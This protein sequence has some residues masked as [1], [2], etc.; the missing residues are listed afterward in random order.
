[1]AQKD[2]NYKAY[3]GKKIAK[4]ETERVD[5]HESIRKKQLDLC[6]EKRVREILKE[7]KEERREKK[8][9]DHLKEQNKDRK[10]EF[11]KVNTK[12]LDYL[13]RK[14]TIRTDLD[15]EGYKA[16]KDHIVEIDEL[17]KHRIE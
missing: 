14:N 2:T 13:A 11:D 6:E 5:N 16:H 9:N 17:Y 3:L 7:K 10:E 4:C 12:R 8:Y 15:R 1:M